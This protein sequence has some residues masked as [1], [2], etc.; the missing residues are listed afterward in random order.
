MRATAESVD[1]KFAALACAVLFAAAGV[2]S[3]AQAPVQGAP[4]PAAPAPAAAGQPPVAQPSAARLSEFPKVSLTAGRSTVLA[5]DFNITRIAITNPAV[6]D[7][8]VVQPREILIDGKTAGTI[9]LIVWGP[10]GRTQYDIVVEQPVTALQQNL[11]ML[12]PGEDIQVSTTEDSTLLSGQVSSTNIMLRAG[13]IAQ[14]SSAKRAV[15]NLL[16]VPGGSESQ[17]VLLQVR[18]AEVNRRVL[19]EVGLSMFLAKQN[20]AAR[21]TTQQFSAP[22]FDD[23]AGGLN[24][25]DFL[26]LFF[27]D[28]LHGYGALLR[29]LESRGAFQSLAEPNLIAYNGQEASFLAGGE[30][31]VPVVQGATG[32]VTVQFKEFGIRLNFKPTIAGDAI[33]LKVKP[34]VSTLDFANGVSLGGFRIPALTTRQGR[35]RRRVARRAV[36]CDCR[37][38]RQS[39]AGRSLGDSD[40]EQAA[41]HRAALQVEGRARRADRVDGSD[42]AAPRA[43][44][45]SGRGSAA[46][47]PLQ[48]VPEQPGQ[49]R[50]RRRRVRGHR[51]GG[52]PGAEGARGR[53]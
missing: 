14:A 47:D 30:F 32:T 41:D 45:G 24:F 25:G 4:T 38:A 43:R 35:D 7:A 18:F 48:A 1:G 17:Q 49:G 34:E 53:E 39:L 37:T 36:V 44:V 8:A 50:R 29:A 3:H 21:T 26:N 2:A 52:C 12:F 23:N 6:A 19:Q 27:F 51:L 15:I 13:E 33:R 28:R 11:A 5:T 40:P 20:W 10:N 22:D 9:S 46:P 42:H 16:Q 31:P